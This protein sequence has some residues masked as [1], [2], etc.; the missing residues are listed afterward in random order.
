MI[1]DYDI[2]KSPVRTEK[3]TALELERKYLFQVNNRAT[4][5]QIK[6]AVEEIYKVKV[7]NVRTMNIRGKQ[8]RV[9]QEVGFTT[10][11][12][13]AIVTLKEGFKLELGA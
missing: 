7:L 5:I 13:K 12:K 2:I 11:W 6:K 10:D 3:G 1:T 8:K 9:R 4:K